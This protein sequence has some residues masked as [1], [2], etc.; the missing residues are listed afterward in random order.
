MN[1]D[2]KSIAEEENKDHNY[3]GRYSR[4]CKIRLGIRSEIS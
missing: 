1:S 4:E 2:I 3:D